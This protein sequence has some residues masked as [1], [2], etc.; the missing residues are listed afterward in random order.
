[1]SALAGLLSTAGFPEAPRVMLGIGLQGTIKQGD[2]CPRPALT[3]SFSPAGWPAP[4]GHEMLGG[5]PCPRVAFVQTTPTVL[6]GGD[7]HAVLIDL[8]RT[9]ANRERLVSS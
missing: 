6:S 5:T 8:L 4:D 9:M 1:M 3:H 2:L 7:R